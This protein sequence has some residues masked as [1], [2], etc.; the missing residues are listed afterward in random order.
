MLQLRHEAI[1]EDDKRSAAPS[2]QDERDVDM[3]RLD[4][5]LRMKNGVH[6]NGHIGD[7][8]DDGS[9]VEDPASEVDESSEESEHTTKARACSYG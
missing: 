1:A 5:K 8:L 9:K 6:L 3:P 7:D 4:D 2:N